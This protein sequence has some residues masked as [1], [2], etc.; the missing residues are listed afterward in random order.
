[1]PSTICS[2]SLQVML[3]DPFAHGTIFDGPSLKVKPTRL[4]PS[5][6]AAVNDVQVPILAIWLSKPTDGLPLFQDWMVTAQDIFHQGYEGWRETV[7]VRCSDDSCFG[8]PVRYGCLSPTKGVAR[9][10]I[11][12]FGVLYTFHNL[13]EKLSVEETADFVRPVEPV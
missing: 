3:N 11:L 7:E 1:M 13:K 5:E 10:S 4:W 6:A 2:K 12:M 8:S 9:S